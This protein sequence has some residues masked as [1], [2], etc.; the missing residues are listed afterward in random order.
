MERL[1]TRENNSAAGTSLSNHLVNRSIAETSNQSNVEAR[2]ENSL[3]GNNTPTTF[4]ASSDS[5]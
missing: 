3:H 4:S 1:E 2:G 5:K